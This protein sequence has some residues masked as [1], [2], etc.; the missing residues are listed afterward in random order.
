MKSYNFEKKQFQ[1]KTLFVVLIN[2]LCFLGNFS[3]AQTLR[4]LRTDGKMIETTTNQEVILRGVNLGQWLNMEGF[5][6]GTNGSMA[7][8]DMKRKLYNSGKSRSTIEYYFDQYRA[9]FITKTDIDYIASKGF[10]CVRLP[11]H[12]ELF[13]TDSQRE[14]RLDVIY[15]DGTAKEAA[16]TDYKTKLQSWVNGNTLA[17]SATVDG[18]VIIDNI[19]SWCKANNMY[20]VLDMHVVPGT[21]GSNTPITDELMSAYTYGEKDFFNDSKNRATLYRIW[22]KISERYK[23]EPTICMYD[24]INEPHGLSDAN[25]G[26][27]RN[28]YNQ[29]IN[30]IRT[31]GDS[32]LILIQGTEFG[33]QYKLNTGVNSLFPS[34]FTIN[35]NLVYNIHRYKTT[36]NITTQNPWGLTN[37]ISYFADAITFQNT[38]NVPLFVGETGLDNDYTQLAGNFDA[39]DNLKFSST[40]WT[41]KHHKDETDKKCL[42]DI[43]G[44]YPWDDLNQWADGSLFNNIKLASCIINNQP[45]FWSAIAPKYPLVT[46]QT[47]KILNYNSGKALDVASSSISNSANVQQST[48]VNTTS[49]QLWTAT[50]SSGWT[51]LNLNSTKALQIA[52]SSIAN[53]GNAD[54]YTNSNA[55]NQKWWIDWQ[56]DGYGYKVTN[57]NSSLLL[58]VASSSTASGANVQQYGTTIANNRRWIFVPV[59]TSATALRTTS[60]Q[61]LDQESFVPEKVSNQNLEVE[62]SVKIF[63]NPATNFITIEADANEF[64]SIKVINMTGSI[65]KTIQ[66]NEATT[67]HTIDI[68]NLPIGVYFV[69]LIGKNNKTISFIK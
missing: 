38:Y 10:N 21:A 61:D 20:I 68:S 31:N 57:K 39:M 28:A 65:L 63:P 1:L 18:F 50:Y 30:D 46:G 14:E 2:V 48:Y 66:I 35:T 69:Q 16:Y 13:L 23:S 62:T 37:H 6:S 12:Y 11:L 52:G 53:G 34:N 5:M 58:E 59:S 19:V 67:R 15:S 17:T 49:S 4:T 51:L 45:S 9:N 25:M 56:S 64:T 55:N 60:N 24:L 27:L 42:L 54:Q 41:Y 33:N 8:V 40:L 29:M 26:T 43:G 36:N 3:E 44:N 32:K 47:Y 7:Q 22:D